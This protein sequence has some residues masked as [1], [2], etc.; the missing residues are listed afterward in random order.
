MGT[1]PMSDSGE[2]LY[3]AWMQDEPITSTVTWDRY[4]TSKLIRVCNQFNECRLF[5]TI[6]KD[7]TCKTLR[8]VGCSGGRFYRF[9]RKV[10][11]SLE[12]QGIDISAAAID[13][14]RKLYPSGN[15]ST[16]DGNL[17][18]QRDVA[19]DIV[20][21]RDVVLHQTNP[22]EFL[23]E[24]YEITRR[25]LILRL[26]TREVGDTVF[27]ASQSCQYFQSGHW[28]PY[29][30]FNTAELIGLIR[31][32][33]PSPIRITGWRH[34]VVLGGDA[35]RFLPKEL[36]YPETGTAETALL[37]EKS[38]GEE[39]NLDTVVTLETRP[40]LRGHDRPIWLRSLRRLAYYFGV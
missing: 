36:Y 9:F 17:K 16:F 18:T 4:K 39:V 20:F 12:Y 34:P 40:E 30:V 21:C 11:P 8:D 27:D 6:V 23:S 15:F 22:S 10:W 32:F 1:S 24:L 25:Y 2:S 7:E 28:V 35:R 14:A 31:S 37:I 33:N 5:H 19:A 29:I 13:H 3:S 38:S 26:R